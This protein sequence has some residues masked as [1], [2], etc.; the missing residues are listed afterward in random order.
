M[1][2]L[3]DF[4]PVSTEGLTGSKKA[5][6]EFVNKVKYGFEGTLIGAGFPLMGKG[7]QLGYKWLGPKWAAKKAAQIGTRTANR[8]VFEPAAWLYSREAVKPVVAATSNAIRGM[9]N[10]TLTKAIAPTI[11]SGLSGFVKDPVTG[12]RVWKW[13]GQLPPFDQWRLGSVTSRD[14]TKRSAKTLDNFLSWFRSY[15]KNPVS[16]EGASEKAM[17]YGRGVARKFD[18]AFAGLEKRA[19]A[20]AKGFEGQYNKGTTSPAMQ[21]Y[22][23]NQ[24][25]EYVF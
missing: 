15:G 18:R 10:W 1:N 7:L 24:V 20:L 14:T 5:A 9:T 13:V 2:P 8:M 16:I 17:L 11:A 6:A 21:K 22:W 3:P 23:L 12:K 19:Y 25:D 4:Q